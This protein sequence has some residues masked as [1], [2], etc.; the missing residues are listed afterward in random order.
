M[1]GREQANT[2]T[3][4]TGSGDWSVRTFPQVHLQLNK[5]VRVQISVGMEVNRDEVIPLFAL[6]GI[7]E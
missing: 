2:N 3:V 7:I 4:V 6:R 1:A 5:R